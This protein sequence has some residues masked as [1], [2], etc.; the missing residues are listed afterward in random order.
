MS[1]RRTYYIP[2]MGDHS[3][4]LAAALRHFGMPAEVLPP[5]NEDSLEAGRRVCGG[6][7]CIPAILALGDLLRK[8]REPGFDPDRAA[9]F[10]PTSCGPCRFGHYTALLRDLLERHGFPGIPIESPNPVNG[11]QDLGGIRPR[12]LRKLVWQGVVAIDLLYRL[13]LETRPY[14]T[15][16]GRTDAV[17]RRALEAAAAAVDAGGGDAL[18]RTLRQAAAGFAA[19][20]ADRSQERPLVGIVGEIYVRWNTYANRDLVREVEALGGEVLLAS[21]AEFFYFSN[22]RVAPV[23]RA[24]GRYRGRLEA[25]LLDAHQRRAEH[26]LRRAVGDAL[27]RPEESGARAVAAAV[28]PFYDAALGSEAVITMGRAIEYARAGVHGLLNV[29]P[30]SCMPGLIAGGMAPRIRRD[31]DG[32]PWLDLPYDAQKETNIRT[33]LEA[34]MHQV[35]QF[36]RRAAGAASLPLPRLTARRRARRRRTG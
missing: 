8:C 36:Q 33:R 15:Q 10:L 20:P 3:H 2:L 19:V 31:L 11:Y 23:A 26:R 1:A 18:E 22:Y 9:F 13:L 4:A 25:M 30:F 17:Y 5:T 29:M 16:A 32:I 12:H 7:E 35:R 14:E 28:E 24:V 6:R 21:I 27:R 34:F